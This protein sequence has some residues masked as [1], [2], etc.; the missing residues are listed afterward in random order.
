[1]LYLGELYELPA[2]T[3]K[4]PSKNDVP[5]PAIDPALVGKPK[6]EA[7]SE[8]CLAHYQKALASNVPVLTELVV[9]E[10]PGAEQTETPD[11]EQIE[12]SLFIDAVYGTGMHGTIKD[13]R[14]CNT[15]DKINA[16]K[17]P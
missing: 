5:E 11:T 3:K 4:K 14:V 16:S 6:T 13:S 15:F 7:M 12:F 17:S 1:V 2:P 8:Q 10:L 9:K